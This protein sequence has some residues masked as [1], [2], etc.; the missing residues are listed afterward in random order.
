MSA[1][2]APLAIDYSE[3]TSRCVTHV[4]HI[5]V[6]AD[7]ITRVTGIVIAYPAFDKA[8]HTSKEIPSH[9]DTLC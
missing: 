4:K 7:T 6:A 2:S 5:A 8:D 3:L 9:V 1:S